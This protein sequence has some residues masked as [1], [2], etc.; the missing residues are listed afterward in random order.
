MIRGFKS[1]T[2]KRIN[3]LACFPVTDRKAS[4]G[5]PA[6]LPDRDRQGAIRFKGRL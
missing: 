4:L 1:A 3:Q 6:P 5:V 2:T